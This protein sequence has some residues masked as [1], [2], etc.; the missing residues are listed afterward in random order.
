MRYETNLWSRASKNMCQSLSLFSC[1]WLFVFFSLYDFVK[2]AARIASRRE[3]KSIFHGQ[4]WTT[5]LL[6]CVFGECEIAVGAEARRCRCNEGDK[7]QPRRVKIHGEEVWPAVW[8][9]KGCKFT[10]AL[11]SNENE[12]R[13]RCAVLGGCWSLPRNCLVIMSKVAAGESLR[14][15]RRVGAMHTQRGNGSRKIL[16][17]SGQSCF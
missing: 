11:F 3:S 7:K 16:C 17:V 1:C 15:L 2:V 5:K 13:R 12:C 10:A 8:P 9:R 14:M 6:L 4:S